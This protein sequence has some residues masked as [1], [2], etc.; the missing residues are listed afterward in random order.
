[1]KRVLAIDTSAGTSV[2]VLEVTETPKLLG[3]WHSDDTMKH[4]ENVGVAIAE[5][6]H[7]AGVSA[8]ELD[9]VVVGRGP[10]PFTGLR[11]GIAAAV[12]F[13]QGIHKPL[14]GVVSLDAIALAEVASG[15]FTGGVEQLLVTT[16]ARR[17]EVYWATYGQ[18]DTQGLPARI[19]G[20]AVAKLA[21]V[22]EGLA[23]AGAAYRG[24]EKTVTA[25]GIARVFLAQYLEGTASTDVSALYLR[26]PDAVPSP[27]KKVSG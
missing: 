21:E 8:R 3:S 24:T 19:S 23:G 27:G 22:H 13:A 9:A 17:G 18:P 1:M 4:A 11:V 12:M 2:A 25:E 7:Q 15:G 20:P 6:L 14:Y 10:A 26:E 5:T 16:D